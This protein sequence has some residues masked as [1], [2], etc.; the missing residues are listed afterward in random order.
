MNCCPFLQSF[1]PYF[2]KALLLG[3]RGQTRESSGCTV[4]VRFRAQGLH[5]SEDLYHNMRERLCDR[6][7][8]TRQRTR[9]WEQLSRYRNLLQ[10]VSIA[11]ITDWRERVR[12]ACRRKL[13][14]RSREVEADGGAKQCRINFIMNISFL[15]HFSESKEDAKTSRELEWL[16]MKNL[17]HSRQACLAHQANSCAIRT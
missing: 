3:T 1:G 9:P 13:R 2:A 7:Q 5:L 16:K 17:L 6:P 4:V 10:P 8:R 14:S 11:R 15:G 12:R